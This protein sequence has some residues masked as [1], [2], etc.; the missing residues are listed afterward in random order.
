MAS[1][2]TGSGGAFAFTGLSEPYWY[3]L[4]VVTADLPASP[5][6]NP[7]APIAV[8]DGQAGMVLSFQ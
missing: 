1:Q 4:L 8:G 2:T 5:T 7:T 6:L 3:Y